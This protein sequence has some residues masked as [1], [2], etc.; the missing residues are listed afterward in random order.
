MTL[1]T[2][3]TDYGIF[4]DPVNDAMLRPSRYAL[5]SADC[6]ALGPVGGCLPAAEPSL[7]ERQL[8]PTRAIAVFEDA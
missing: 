6:G 8:R 3:V 1:R 2:W 5:G 7:S 4:S